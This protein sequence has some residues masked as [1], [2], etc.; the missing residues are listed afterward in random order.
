MSCVPFD[1]LLWG[2]VVLLPCVAFRDCVTSLGLPTDSQIGLGNTVLRGSVPQVGEVEEGY[3]KYKNSSIT[4][5]DVDRHITFCQVCPSRNIPLQ[6]CCLVLLCS[7][8]SG[9][10]VAIVTRAVGTIHMSVTLYVE[11]PMHA[12]RLRKVFPVRLTQIKEYI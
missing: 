6:S 8:W 1:A 2:S 3:R 7:W 9:T 10:L 11:L 4:K 12:V 5:K